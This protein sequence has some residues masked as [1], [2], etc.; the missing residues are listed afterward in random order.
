MLS[1][2]SSTGEGDT[3]N[4]LQATKDDAAKQ[5]REKEVSK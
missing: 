5:Q 2:I 3:K 1:T 4:A